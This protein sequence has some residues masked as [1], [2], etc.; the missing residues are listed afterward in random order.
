MPDTSNRP[1]HH[2]DLRRALIETALDMLAEEKGWQFTL[3][4]V[5]RRAGVSHAAPYKHFP[6]KAALLAE[7]AMIG[8]DRLRESLSV[9]KPTAPKSLRDEVTSVAHA[10]VAFG[11]NNPALYRLMFSAGEEKVAGL[12]LNERALAV[13]DVAL[14]ILRRGQAA[15]SIRKRPIEGQAAAWWGLIHGMTML[16]IDGLLVPEKV[17]SAPLDAALNTLVEGLENPAT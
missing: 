11:T 6:D 5:A 1:Y 17:G 7:L 3:R 2:G 13:F 12:H 10:Y 8:F 9:A 16:A 14:E 15:G 4:E